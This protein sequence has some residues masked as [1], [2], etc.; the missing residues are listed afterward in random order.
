[1]GEER[2]C[3]CEIFQRT[4]EFFHNRLCHE[5]LC[6]TSRCCVKKLMY[7]NVEAS[8]L[9]LR[10]ISVVQVISVFESWRRRPVDCVLCSLFVRCSCERLLQFSPLQ[11]PFTSSS[12]KVQLPLTEPSKTIW[13]K[14]WIRPRIGLQHL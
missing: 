10:R 2:S 9:R 8:R 13:A 5:P 4:K 14:I 11:W 6:Q 1:M 7:C 12:D 3:Y